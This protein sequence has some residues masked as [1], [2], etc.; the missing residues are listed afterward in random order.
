MRT[1][2]KFKTALEDEGI[3]QIYMRYIFP[4]ELSAHE[5]QDQNNEK[6]FDP[7][8]RIV[9]IL[10]GLKTLARSKTLRIVTPYKGLIHFS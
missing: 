4:V 10:K 5:H 1:A 8:D 2:E 3:D 9:E 7:D 6:D